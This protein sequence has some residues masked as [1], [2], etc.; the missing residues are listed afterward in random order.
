LAKKHNFLLFE[1]RKFIDIGHTVQ[2]QYHGG[3]LRISEFAHVANIAILSGDDCV[4]ALSQVIKAPDFP[5][6]SDRAFLLLAEMTS[7]GSLAIGEYTRKCVEAARANADSVIGFVA[8]TS[9]GSVDTAGEQGIE[10]FLVFTTGIN[11]S[12]KG[13]ALGQQYQTPTQ[14]IKG[15]TDFIIAGRGIYG[16]A[17]PVEAAKVYRQEAWQAY[18]E[19]VGEST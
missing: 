7:R 6:G 15:G 8:T 17:D 1:D 2:R 9:L 13:D 5:Y 19:R 3:V 14:A 4:T 11:Q 12:S 18:L 16:S 10:D